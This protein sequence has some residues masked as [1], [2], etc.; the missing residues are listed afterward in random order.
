MEKRLMER[1]NV[2]L[3]ATVTF[4]GFPTQQFETINISD[5]GALLRA[6]QEVPE[7]TKFFMSLFMGERATKRPLVMVGGTVRRRSES[8]LALY[9]DQ[10]QDFL[11]YD[12]ELEK[13]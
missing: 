6:D 13:K 2:L 5:D 8:G 1:H 12:P 4:A 9:F 10:R 11:S 7:G 3:P